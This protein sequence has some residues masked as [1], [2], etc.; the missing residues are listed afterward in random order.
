MNDYPIR[1]TISFELF[2]KRFISGGR[3]AIEHGDDRIWKIINVDNFNKLY[4]IVPMNDSEVK[5][6]D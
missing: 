6:A 5:H 3:F 4:T 1:M 2:G